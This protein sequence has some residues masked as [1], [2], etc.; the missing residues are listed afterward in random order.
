MGLYLKKG[1][2]R[3]KNMTVYLYRWQQYI[4][5]NQVAVIALFW[6]PIY[7]EI[8]CF[9]SWLQND[10]C[11]SHHHITVQD[12]KTVEKLTASVSFYQK[13]QSLPKLSNHQLRSRW[14][15]QCGICSPLVTE[16]IESQYLTHHLVAR[17]IAIVLVSK[18]NWRMNIG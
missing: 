4:L 9:V 15:C 10:C 17:D 11:N 5:P 2:C 13:S 18:K 14:L 3:R 16:K 8:S 12:R 7:M 1:I 6:Q